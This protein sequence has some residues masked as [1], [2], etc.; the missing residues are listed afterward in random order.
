MLTLNPYE[1]IIDF[2][3]IKWL[4]QDYD[5]PTKELKKYFEKLFHEDINASYVTPED[6][7][8]NLVKQ[9]IITTGFVKFSVTVN[10]SVLL[11]SSENRTQKEDL[12]ISGED[13]KPIIPILKQVFKDQIEKYGQLIEELNF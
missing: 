13:A 12:F 5:A 3:K 9:K 1:S 8:Y 7:V 4:I 6:S 11:M 10:G 2:R